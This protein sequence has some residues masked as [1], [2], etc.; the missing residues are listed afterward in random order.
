MKRAVYVCQLDIFFFFFSLF[1]FSFSTERN[2][3]T[4]GSLLFREVGREFRSGWKGGRKERKEG[5][6]GLE[7]RARE[8][9]EASLGIKEGRERCNRATLSVILHR[10]SRA[11]SRGARSTLLADPKDESGAQIV[12][13]QFLLP[14][15]S[16]SWWARLSS[17]GSVEK[18]RCSDE[19]WDR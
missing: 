16:S 11:F 13:F 7:E 10:F 2:E 8:I 3:R 17:G 12:E 14:S 15:S 19:R 5:R 18:A 9:F 1:L 4:T 6:V